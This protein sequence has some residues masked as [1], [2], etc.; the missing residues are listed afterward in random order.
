MAGHHNKDVFVSWG[1]RSHGEVFFIPGFSLP[2]VSLCPAYCW[3]LI[4]S[5]NLGVP[6]F[7]KE[8]QRNSKDLLKMQNGVWSNW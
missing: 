7:E 8:L 1:G 3:M 2:F 4:L 6:Q 5:Y